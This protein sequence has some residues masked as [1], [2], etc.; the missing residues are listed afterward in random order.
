MAFAFVESNTITTYPV[1]ASDVRARFPNVSF[2]SN[3]D[4]LS[5]ADLAEYGVVS[6]VNELRPSYDEKTQTLVEGAPV[7]NAGVWRQT[8]NVSSLSAELIATKLALREHTQRTRRDQELQS[9]DWVVTMHKELGTTIP[10]AW[11]TY[12]Q[13]LRD[14][15][16]QAG[17]PDNITWPTKPS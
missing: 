11:K 6:V 3:L 2:P 17:F 9:C 4:S 5:A 10:A 13:E 12:R 8:W 16:S 7:L 15:P 1:S 14:V